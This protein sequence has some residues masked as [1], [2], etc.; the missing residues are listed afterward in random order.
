MHEYKYHHPCLPLVSL[1]GLFTP[2]KSSSWAA[3]V[4][5][6]DIAPLHGALSEPM[7]YIANH[8]GQI[9]HHCVS[10]YGLVYYFGLNR[11]DLLFFSFPRCP[12]P[13]LSPLLGSAAV[14][15]SPKRSH[16]SRVQKGCHGLGW[17]LQGS[18]IQI[19]PLLA[20]YQD[21]LRNTKPASYCQVHR[22]ARLLI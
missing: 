19:V 1:G 11:R 9:F 7:C 21:V 5:V 2:G 6:I 10:G 8:V 3:V 14:H 15:R 12:P 18:L 4:V 13:R 20:C 17:Y 16:R 22:E